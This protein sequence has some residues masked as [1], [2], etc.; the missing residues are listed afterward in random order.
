[1]LSV[2]RGLSLQ[3][4]A[5]Q[6]LLTS[7]GRPALSI[8]TPQ[9]LQR[10]CAA[11]PVARLQP[12]G[13]GPQVRGCR[14][15]LGVQALWGC[16]ACRAQQQ[17]QAALQ[18]GREARAWQRWRP[19]RRAA[20]SGPR[21]SSL[22]TLQRS[23]GPDVHTAASPRSLLKEKRIKASARMKQLSQKVRQ[24]RLQVRAGR[25]GGQQG[26]RAAAL[27]GGTL[28]CLRCCGT[29]RR[30]CAL[31]PPPLLLLL[32]LGGHRAHFRSCP[33]LAPASCLRWRTAFAST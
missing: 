30:V 28:L 23:T 25:A 20:L 33:A 16:S 8:P 1:M 9:G 14:G 17:Q 5:A 13:P 10:L 6:D 15:L 22:R 11:Q 2:S 4:C 31:L 18:R 7:T 24:Q 19:A 12:Q 32:C 29:L 26:Q 3:L 21:S 27:G